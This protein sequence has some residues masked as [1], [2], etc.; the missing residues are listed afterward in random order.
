MHNELQ[1]QKHEFHLNAVDLYEG[2]EDSVKEPPLRSR[3]DELI[4]KSGMVRSQSEQPVPI[5][6]QPV[7]VP[8]QHN[9]LR[10][11]KCFELLVR[12]DEFLFVPIERPDGLDTPE[13][14]CSRI[15]RFWRITTGPPCTTEVASYSS[16][17]HTHA[18]RCTV[19]ICT[20]WDA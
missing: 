6:M 3:E 5:P 20:T 8:K 4:E 7:P 13:E 12:D 14:S 16:F 1:K 15:R 10:C 9:G 11:K 19:E 2:V 17:T 18:R